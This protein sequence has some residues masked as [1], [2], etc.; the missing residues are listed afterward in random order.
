[1]SDEQMTLPDVPPVEAYDIP[2]PVDAP[3]RDEDTRLDIPPHMAPY[4][5]LLFDPDSVFAGGR[6]I[7]ATALIHTHAFSPE[8]AVTL[9]GRAVQRVSKSSAA[10]RCP[11]A[12]FVTEGYHL[13]VGPGALPR[14]T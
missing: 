14:A 7:D 11:Q 5:V 10:W 4:T 3:D 9:A 8:A 12:L 1:M 13:N 6:I 2:D